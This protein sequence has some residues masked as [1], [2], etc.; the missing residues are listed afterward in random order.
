MT[1]RDNPRIER[2]ERNGK[3]DMKKKTGEVK[4]SVTQSVGEKEVEK[5]KCFSLGLSFSFEKNLGMI[6]TDCKVASF[7][8]KAS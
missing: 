8:S 7:V 2:N 6:E 3:K 5:Y 4:R 1:G